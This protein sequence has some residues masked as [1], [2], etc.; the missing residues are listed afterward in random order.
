[1]KHV[2]MLIRSHPANYAKLVA[3]ARMRD[4]VVR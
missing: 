1:V 2:L 4:F 3:L